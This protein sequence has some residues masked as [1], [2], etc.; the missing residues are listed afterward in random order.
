MRTKN[1]NSATLSTAFGDRRS[2]WT[3]LA[4]YASAEQF[5]VG[6]RADRSR[7]HLQVHAERDESD[8]R[9]GAFCLKASA[10][11]ASLESGFHYDAV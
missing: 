7:V 5:Q 1:E 4:T 11:P 9:Y 6:I 2:S 10:A 3:R 8:L